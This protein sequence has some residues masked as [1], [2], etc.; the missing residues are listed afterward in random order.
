MLCTCRGFRAAK[1]A[2]AARAFPDIQIYT[3]FGSVTGPAAEHGAASSQR[4]TAAA[5]GDSAASAMHMQ[6]ACQGVY[7]VQLHEADGSSSGGEAEHSGSE[8]NGLDKV[9][10]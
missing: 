4:D 10:L 8:C 2:A 3:P 6:G 1:P 7:P 9:W 5:A